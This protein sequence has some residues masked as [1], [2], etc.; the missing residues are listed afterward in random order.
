[1]IVGCAV[2]AGP[3]PI[4]LSTHAPMKLLYEFALALQILLPKQIKI[5]IISTGRRPK[6]VWI[7]TLVLLVKFHVQDSKSIPDEITKSEHQDS[8]ASKLYNIGQVRVERDDI[9]SE[10]R[11]LC[12]NQH[13]TQG[14]KNSEY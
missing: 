9:V 3:A 2:S 1:M 11:C 12:D 6:Q 8:N 5:D 13:V 10:H 4:P 7:G 14:D